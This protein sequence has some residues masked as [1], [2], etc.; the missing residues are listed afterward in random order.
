MDEKSDQ[1]GGE[2]IGQ[3]LKAHG[4]EHIFM[5]NNKTA[6]SS[7]IYR[8][9]E[10]NG[11]KVVQTKH[12]VTA[13]TAADANSRVTGLPG[14]AII[15]CAPG[16]NNTLAAIKEAKESE[17]AVL[18]IGMASSQILKET[19][20]EVTNQMK[21]LKPLVKWTGKVDRVRDIAYEL[22]EA[23][24]Q[25]LHGT[26][27]PVYIQFTLDCL[28]P[29]PVVKKEL[30][31]Q[32]TSW[33]RDYYI[34]NLF[35]AGFDVGRE[36]RPWPIEIPFPKKEL[37]S[38][39]VKAI[40][41]AERPLILMG[42]QAA[43]P[44]I[45]ESKINSILTDMGIPCFL[46]GLSRGVLPKSHQLYMKH[47]L[48]EAI[49]GSDCILVLGMSSTF[50]GEKVKSKVAVHV[51]NRNKTTLKSNASQFGSHSHQIHSDVGQFLVEVSEK[52]G[53]FAISEEWLRTLKETSHEG[54]KSARSSSS[55]LQS[56]M[57]DVIGDRKTLIISDGSSFSTESVDVLQCKGP[58]IE[59]SHL[60]MNNSFLAGYALG[61]K[62]GRRDHLTVSLVDSSNISYNISEID[63][64]LSSGAANLVV[65]VN[66]SGKQVLLTDPAT[67]SSITNIE[68]SV[69]EAGGQGVSVRSSDSVPTLKTAVTKALT[70]VQE[71]YPVVLSV[72]Q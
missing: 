12:E 49:N 9:A 53:R 55:G 7:P 39:T 16:I 22:R 45:E 3:V 60:S 64:Y 20:L 5:L 27:G 66:S 2:I 51:V 47:G 48:K 37:V 21:T 29:F 59:S 57:D 40:T 68:T 18:L 4:V 13:V 38:K 26:P 6:S 10:K 69:K 15:S 42:S 24:R 19:H 54:E 56:T 28:Y 34:Q 31:R 52:L 33:Y 11:I 63:T 58:W 44:P 71:G 30:D 61:A 70:H 17:S 25:A 67:G 32:G 50:K 14:V 43:L 35:A 41:K 46:F 23:L 1:H 72:Q 36:I 62:L 65:A 8:G